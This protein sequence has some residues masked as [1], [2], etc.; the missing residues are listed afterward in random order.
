MQQLKTELQNYTDAQLA[1]QLLEHHDE[2]TPE[3][4]L[5]LEEEARKRNLDLDK[6]REL[7]EQNSAEPTILQMDKEDFKPFDHLFTRI[8]LELAAVILR[9]NQIPF[10]ADNF[11]S[12]ATIPLESEAAPQFSIH[13][14]KSG[15]EKAHELLDEHFEKIEGSYRL[16]KMSIKEQLKLFSF[17]ELQLSEYDAMEEVEVSLSNQEKETIRSFGTK[18]LEESDQIEKKQDRVLFYYDTIETVIERLTKG[19]ST[20]FSKTE[21]LTILEI[22]QVTCDEPEFPDFMDEAISSLLGFFRPEEQ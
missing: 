10:F 5:L 11:R 9:D 21:L 16:K 12:T 15:I 18:V 7:L 3:A 4:L 22:L 14:H 2:Y 6:Q 19:D 20:A 8:D 13:V 1:A 17:H